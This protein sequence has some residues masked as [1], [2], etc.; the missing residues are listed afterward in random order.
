MKN[1]EIAIFS[2]SQ[3]ITQRIFS[4]LA[5]RKLDIPVYEY[6]YADLLDK[7]EQLIQG[8]TKVLISRGGTAAVLRNH[9]NIPVVEIAHDLHGIYR[10]LQE[11][12][13]NVAEDRSGGLSALLSRFTL[14][15]K[16]GPG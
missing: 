4:V 2:V 1:N 10:I 14:L 13:K 15:P 8:G 16:Y 6:H 12:R 3:T 11:A 5:E 9:L 7:A